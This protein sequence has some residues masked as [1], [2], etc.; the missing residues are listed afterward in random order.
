MLAKTESAEQVAKLAPRT[1]IALCETPLGVLRASSIAACDE[2]AGLMW[3]AEDLLA[4][5]GG[6]SSRDATGRYR[7]VAR[8]AR[9]WV[10]LAAGAC[11]KPAIDS[12]FLDMSDLAGLAAETEDAA[13][14]GFAAKACIHPVQV[15][16]VRES[17]RPTAESIAW[18]ERLLAAATEPG[19]FRFEGAMVDEPLLRQAR[20]ILARRR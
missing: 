5:L 14:S 4:A 6:S 11:G 15:P 13:S 12:V 7:D 8:H 17:F 3:G 2:V 9:S 18:A 1:V 19:V 16:V 10:L 20:T